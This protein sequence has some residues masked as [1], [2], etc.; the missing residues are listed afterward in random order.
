MLHELSSR[1][2]PCRV[3]HRVPIFELLFL[4]GLKFHFLHVYS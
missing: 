3:F 1:P 4:I 2:L